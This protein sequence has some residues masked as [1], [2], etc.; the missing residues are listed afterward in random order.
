[1]SK[2]TKTLS[3][4]LRL[5]LALSLS[6]A[7]LP[8]YSQTPPIDELEEVTVTAER[9]AVSVQ[10][11]PISAVAFSG[12]ALEARNVKTFEELQYQ[13][14]S[15]TFTDNGNSK[16]INIRGVGVSEAAPNQ[17]V[18]V[19]VHMDGAYIARE[20][21]FGDALFD[22]E[23]VEVLRGPQGTY[24]GQNA[25][26]GAVFI[27][28]KRPSFTERDGFVNA[29]F[30]EFDQRRVG[31]G[32]SF[33]LGDKVAFRVAGDVERR[34][35]FYSN[36]GAAGVASGTKVDDQPGNLNRELY[37]AQVLFQPVESL[38]MRIVHERSDVHTDGVPYRL[39][40]V[41]GTNILP[42]SGERD[43]NY[44]MEGERKVT[45]NRTTGLF[46]WQANDYF[47]VLANV[48]YLE[49]KQ[50]F[51]ADTDRA[52]FIT[53]T[54]VQNGSDFQI[55]DEYWSTEVN[56]V[57]TSE[58]PFEWTIGA[59]RLDYE[60]KNY[61][62][63]LRYNNAQFPGTTVNP[64]RHT[65]L[66][67]FLDNIRKNNAFFGEIG[68]QLTPS[69]QVKFGLR[70]NEDDVGFDRS[71]YQS[72][73]NTFPAG[74]LSHYNAPTGAPLPAGILNFKK[75]T[76]RVVLNY[77]PSEN[78]LF[79][80]TAGRG[81]KPGGTTPLADTYDSEVVSNYEFGWK[82]DLLDNKLSMS[83]SFF[84][85]DYDNF[86]RT[87]S[88]D[89]NNPAAAQTNNVDG[90]VIKGLEAQ[91]GGVIG[92]F[93]W[94]LS[95]ALNKGTYGGLSLV[96]PV[97]IA[98]GVN[99][100]TASVFNLSGLSIDYLPKNVWN[101]GLS[102]QGLT[103][104][105]GRLVPSVRVSH[106]DQYYTAFYHFD[107]NLT[108]GKTIYDANVAYESDQDWRV[109]LYARNLTDKTYISRAR[110]GNDARGEYFLGSPRQVGVRLAYRF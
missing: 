80:A 91:L 19:A 106:Q 65:R 70:R 30:G 93:R 58:G 56:L 22:L 78:H 49:S 54:T 63:F 87:Y 13:V 28:S 90:S 27:N 110:G 32:V 15:M 73:G 1:M 77:K 76:G 41:R 97:G 72:A 11:I 79:Y 75:T 16:F 45:Y 96:L 43:L 103:I 85:M 62:N 44:D 101:F 20:F 95:Y 38:S 2:N 26:G 100:R 18:G 48:S 12:D 86:Q 8:A 33:A 21:V 59:S 23:G 108:P 102:Y 47:K 74:Q 69:F 67:F 64:P 105:S 104:G 71:S 42:T 37:R 98:D 35:S 10:E 31:A 60:Q 39:F 83:Y 24:S 92:K 109:E 46:D 52:A 7:L 94:D 17:T 50:H 89:P 99:P 53:P 55:N 66:Y 84:Y 5:L 29:E 81:Y 36:Y 61:L 34:D 3:S 25:A 4:R 57:S 88:P 68:Y 6:A 51:L 40:P 14:P 107:Y 82:A 9:R